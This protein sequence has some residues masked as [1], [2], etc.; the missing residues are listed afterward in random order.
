[1]ASRQGQPLQFVFL[2]MVTF[3]SLHTPI[4][5]LHT[6]LGGPLSL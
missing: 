2:Q 4:L 6:S 5:S 3:R 1:V